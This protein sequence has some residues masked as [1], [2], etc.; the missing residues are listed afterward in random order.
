M[1]KSQKESKN[2]TIVIFPYL[3]VSKELTI[4][5]ITIKPSFANIIEQEEPAI[6]E[7][8][9]TVA[10]FFRYSYDKQI[11]LWSY[12]VTHLSCKKDWELLRKRL[13]KF[14]TILRY[15]KLSDFPNNALFSHFD[16]FVFEIGKLQLDKKSDFRYYEGLLNGENT[17]EVCINK[18]KIE[19]PFSFHYEIHPLKLEDIEN[20]KFLQSFYYS[21]F[22]IQE[23]KRLH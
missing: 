22:N 18:D 5:A 6:K 12:Y 10:R 4:D 7:Q 13:N 3:F 9:L 2:L 14:T 17:I 11:N 20:D 21:D 23:E 19:K 1:V 8:L 16:Y 15:S